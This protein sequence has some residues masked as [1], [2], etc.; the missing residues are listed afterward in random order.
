MNVTTSV[1]EDTGIC[2]YK[3]RGRERDKKDIKQMRDGRRGETK[4]GK[5]VRKKESEREREG[6]R[7]KGE[8][9]R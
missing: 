9:D 7:G 3:E 2:R 8:G 1:F 4:R 6:E 5:R